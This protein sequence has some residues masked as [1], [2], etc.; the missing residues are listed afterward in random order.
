MKHFLILFLPLL[1]TACAGTQLERLSGQAPA[2]ELNPYHAALFSELLTLSEAEY[3]EG[4]YRDSDAFAIKA[5]A[6]L[7]DGRIGPDA[8]SS[9]DI[10]AMHLGEMQNTFSGLNTLLQSGGDRAAPIHMARA[11]AHYDCWL[12][13]QEENFQPD[14]IARCRGIT[15]DAMDKVLATL[16]TPTAASKAHIVFFRFN[17]ADLADGAVEVVDEVARLMKQ[18]PNFKAYLYGHADSPGTRHYNKTLSERRAKMV[19]R[20]LQSHGISPERIIS[21]FYGEEKPMVQR[22]QGARELKNRRVEIVLSAE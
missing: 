9:R 4:D 20:A 11:V 3:A 10:P 8:P 15:L 5:Q 12:Q 21:R 18:H 14:H 1:L 19:T 6:S 2:G 13:E 17:R 22:A 16:Q 7:S